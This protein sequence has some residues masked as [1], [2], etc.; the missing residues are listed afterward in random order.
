M[1][2]EGVSLSLRQFGWDTPFAEQSQTNLSPD[3]IRRTRLSVI[4]VKEKEVSA[5]AAVKKRRY[6]AERMGELKDDV[7]G[8]EKEGGGNPRGTTTGWRRMRKALTKGNGDIYRG[9][10]IQR[11]T[12]VW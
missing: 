6:A 9:R 3:E 2:G 5:S 8:W 4:R 10:R 7:W 12:C 11:R 1:K